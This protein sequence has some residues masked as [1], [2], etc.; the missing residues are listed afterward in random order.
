MKTLS[1]VLVGAVLTTTA[2]MVAPDP[3]NWKM[4]ELMWATYK[5]PHGEFYREEPG[6]TNKWK[7]EHNN[8]LWIE[9]FDGTCIRRIVKVM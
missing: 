5:T 8:G 1:K 2:Q 3:A 9:E 6:W 4:H 7:I